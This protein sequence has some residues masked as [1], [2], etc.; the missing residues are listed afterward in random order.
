MTNEIHLY[1]ERIRESSSEHTLRAY[2]QNLLALR[3]FC[4]GQGVTHVEGLN[5]RLLRA[6]LAD[7]S[8]KGL[9]KATLARYL[10]A[11]RSFVKAR[12]S[13]TA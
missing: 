6:F 12:R 9:K 5:H 7:L 3:D 10:A 13:E 2:R 8:G 11:V 4:A 1:L